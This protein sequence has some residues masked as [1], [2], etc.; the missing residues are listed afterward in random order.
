[1]T[2]VEKRKERVKKRENPLLYDE[3]EKLKGTVKSEKALLW[4]PSSSFFPI[5]S[6]VRKKAPLWRRRLKL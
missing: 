4:S 2:N 3:R 1:M 5:M 6:I